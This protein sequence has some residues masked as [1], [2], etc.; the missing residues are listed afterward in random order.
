MV[1]EVTAL[2]VLRGGDVTGF[3]GIHG[4]LHIVGYCISEVTLSIKHS[5]A[6]ALGQPT[7]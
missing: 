2:K 5:Q 1:Y 4:R 7:S 3:L 6:A